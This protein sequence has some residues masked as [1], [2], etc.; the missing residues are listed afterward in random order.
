MPPAQD[1]A[2]LQAEAGEPLDNVLRASGFSTD[3]S[4]VSIYYVG[5]DFELRRQG[6]ASQLL[7]YVKRVATELRCARGAVAYGSTGMLCSTCMM[8]SMQYGE[9]RHVMEQQCRV[10]MMPCKVRACCRQGARLRRCRTAW[11]R[12]NC[13]RHCFPGRSFFG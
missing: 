13:M 10:R 12:N 6:V 5:V 7:Q 4:I 2:R 1:Y 3:D 11:E 8:P 9:V